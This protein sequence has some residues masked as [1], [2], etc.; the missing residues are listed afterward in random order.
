MKRLNPSWYLLFSA[1]P[2]YAHA[3]TGFAALHG[4]EGALAYWFH[5][6]TEPDHLA[7][8]AGSVALLWM[9]GRRAWRPHQ[10][11]K[12]HAATKAYDDAR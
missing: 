6:L 1:L 12:K 2:L 11:N 4:E 7:L 9:M 5:L 3:H 8:L 10:T